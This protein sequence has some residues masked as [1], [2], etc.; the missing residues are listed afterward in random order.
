[1][2]PSRLVFSLAWPP[3]PTLPTFSSLMSFHCLWVLLWKATSLPRSFPVGR[4]CLQLRNGKCSS[5]LVVYQSCLLFS[6]LIFPPFSRTLRDVFLPRTR[7]FPH[8]T[9]NSHLPLQDRTLHPHHSPCTTSSSPAPTTI[10]TA[11]SPASTTHTQIGFPALTIHTHGGFP[12]SNHHTQI[13]FPALTIHTHGGLPSSNHHTQIGFPALTHHTYDGLPSLITQI[14]Y[15]YFG[16]GQHF[17][18]FSSF[19][20]DV[21]KSTLSPWMLPRFL[22]DP[23]KPTLP[24]WT[25]PIFLISFH[26]LGII[27]FIKLH[28]YDHDRD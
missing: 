22:I 3:P 21:S 13:G 15:Y 7:P 27:C 20:M 17:L 24:L 8:R 25:W 11:D 12:S 14:S 2:P 18:C 23:R 1:V 9:G 5:R 26:Q 19:L 16:P 6:C 10:H 28:V 4:Q